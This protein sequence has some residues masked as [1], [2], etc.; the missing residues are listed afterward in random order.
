MKPDMMP[1]YPTTR[2]SLVVDGTTY[3]NISTWMQQKRNQ[4]REDTYDTVMKEMRYSLC[5]SSQGSEVNPGKDHRLE[6]HEK[7]LINSQITQYVAHDQHTTQVNPSGEIR[8]GGTKPLQGEV[9][10]RGISG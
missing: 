6:I 10:A 9:R 4:F 3:M 5:V 8:K 2:H 1:L 7:Q